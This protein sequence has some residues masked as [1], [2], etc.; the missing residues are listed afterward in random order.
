[1]K[2]LI[3][4]LLFVVSFCAKTFSQQKTNIKFG[5]IAAQDF[6]VNSPL[7]DSDSKAV[8]IA[9]I[10]STSFVGN[11]KG[12]FTYVY[13]R[14]LRIKI[15]KKA[16][17]DPTHDLA[18]IRIRLYQKDD[19]KEILSDVN[20]I[21]YN[22]ENESVSQTILNPQDI[23]EERIDKYFVE[24]KFTLPNVKEGSLFEVSYII[25]SDFDFNLP[26]WQFQS[27][28]YPCL[29]SEY[30]VE[31]PSLLIYAVLR[32]GT[33][34]FF[35][36]KQGQQY[37][38][39][40]VTQ[41]HAP[42]DYGSKDQDLNIGT[43]VNTYRWVM[44]DIPPLKI[45]DY[46]SSPRNYVDKIEFQ[47]S[48]TSDGET[49]KNVMSTWSQVIDE[50]LKAKD[51]GEPLS[52]E[53]YWLGDDIASLT[54]GQQDKLQIAK[55]IFKYVQSNFTCTNYNVVQILT[56][57]K[58]V[59]AK[60]NG[61][62]GEINLLLT[63]MLRKKG[64]EADPM[65]LSTREYGYN[66]PKY[67]I[68]QKFNYVI[69]KAVIDNNIYYLDACHPRLGF[70]KLE[71]NCYNGYARVISNIK[72][73]SIYLMPDSIQEKKVVTVFISNKET[74]NVQAKK[75]AVLGYFES[76]ELRDKLVETKQ[77]EFMKDI[78]KSFSPDIDLENFSIDSL[79]SFE[80]PI[81]INYDFKLKFTDDVVYFNPMLGEDLKKNPF[82]EQNRR[83]PIAMPYCSD[84]TYLFNMEIPKGYI[85]DAL[86]KS[87]R[88]KL[89]E[90]EGYFEY[91]IDQ[92]NDRIRLR[93]TIHLSKASF[94]ADR[95][96]SL[97]DFFAYVVKKQ[98]E[99][100]VF[101]KTN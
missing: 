97:R 27:L 64:I 30:S 80:F 96:Q 74:G 77:E 70:G 69:C 6:I 92:S 5:K 34:S 38:R 60:H 100:I 89:N 56:S 73:D 26:G 78:K 53:N 67:P 84:N 71:S 79:N 16:A 39:Y 66:Y 43:A 61:T 2:K 24:K 41:P 33:D 46:I 76:L 57:L 85:V 65:I 45:E 7:I 95:Y 31:I 15:L 62:V 68:L 18:T 29:W 11:N 87:A 88:V 49:T 25:T 72:P 82:S 101:K 52:S 23:F 90:D 17:L 51:F 4:F 81:T 3:F 50:L 42:T 19:D 44:K 36:S 63:C 21:S 55:N 83:Y 86:P 12:W 9:D 54:L 98:A 75:Q 35:I 13:K 22:L 37:Q 59:Y 8:I 1:M 10:G 94:N 58:N 93:S 14:K 99:F 28:R 20:A 40:L 91:I 48:Q 47:L 32:Q